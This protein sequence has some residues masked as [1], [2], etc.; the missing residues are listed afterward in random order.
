MKMTI[1]DYITDL[2]ERGYAEEDAEILADVM[3][4]ERWASEDEYDEEAFYDDEAV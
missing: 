3:F 2:I 4:S 1:L